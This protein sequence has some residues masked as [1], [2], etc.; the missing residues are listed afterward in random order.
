MFIILDIDECE[1][2]PCQN[3][4]TCVDLINDYQCDCMDGFNGTNCTTGKFEHLWYFFYIKLGI[5]VFQ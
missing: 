4:G 2:R 1:V 3:N 5:T